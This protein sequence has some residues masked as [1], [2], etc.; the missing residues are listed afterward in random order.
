MSNAAARRRPAKAVQRERPAGELKFAV[1]IAP[2]DGERDDDGNPV[3]VTL[4][5]DLRH[6]TLAERQLV[7]RI[8]A[9]FAEPVEAEDVVLAHAF[10]VWRRTH[11]DASLQRWMDDIEWGTLL[12]SLNM[13]PGRTAWDTTPE[14]YDP[15]A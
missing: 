5:V 7:K 9:K 8:M 14:G 6:F 11:P 4:E 2:P 3:P 10:T 12:D 1:I 15:E 13:E